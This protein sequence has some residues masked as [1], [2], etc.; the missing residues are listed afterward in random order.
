GGGS[1][2]QSRGAALEVEEGLAGVLGLDLVR[3]AAGAGADGLHRPH[4][5]L[6]QVEVVDALV[7]ER[8]AAVHRPRAAPA[9]RVTAVEVR[10]RTPPLEAH[11][12]KDRLA[13]ASRV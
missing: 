5:P 4:E 9:S 7:G 6:Q 1:F 8:A 2:D 13:E 3:E 12:A 11:V 10:L